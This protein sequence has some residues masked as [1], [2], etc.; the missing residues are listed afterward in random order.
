MSALPKP[1]YTLEEYPGLDKNSE[2][3][4][5]YW[6]GE[7]F[8]MSGGSQEHAEIELN[9]IETLHPRLTRQG[10][11]MFPANVRIRV[12][13]LPPYRYADLSALCGQAQFV[14]TGGLDALTNPALIIEVL[15]PSTEAFDRGDKFTSSQSIPDFREYL[16][17]A[18]H[19]HHITQ[20]L[21][22]EDGS[23]LHREF[24]S[25]TDTL[26]LMTGNCDLSLSEVY[27]NLSFS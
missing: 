4:P 24:N 15:S 8:D 12:P 16:L 25:L 17:V 2:A 9:L 26:T 1:H 22:Q 20:L 3:R 18:R 23:W 13:S 10:C 7:V 27:R 21:R 5:G 11:R 6:N 14:E 19:R